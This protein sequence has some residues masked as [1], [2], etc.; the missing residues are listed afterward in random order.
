MSS[1]GLHL[2]IEKVSSKYA[3]GLWLITG[4]GLFRNFLSK[5]K[6]TESNECWYFYYEI[7]T[8]THLMY[9]CEY[10][11]RSDLDLN[12]IRDFQIHII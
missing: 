10:I 8:S 11:D 5:I 9:D 3:Y 2:D 6:S 4:H 12:N 7:E 1:F